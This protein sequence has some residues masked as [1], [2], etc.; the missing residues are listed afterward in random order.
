MIYAEPAQIRQMMMWI[1]F[2]QPGQTIKSE[3]D[4]I[5]SCAYA[6]IPVMETGDYRITFPDPGEQARSSAREDEV[7]LSVPAGKLEAFGN[8]MRRTQKMEEESVWRHFLLQP[9]FPR[10]DFYVKQYKKWGLDTKDNE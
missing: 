5:D 8:S 7:I 10:P 9:D 2:S 6:I 1:K 3:F 4:P